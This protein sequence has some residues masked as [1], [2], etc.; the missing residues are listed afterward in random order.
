MSQQVVIDVLAVAWTIV[1]YFK[2]STLAYDL[3]DEICKHLS[4]DKHKLQQD[5][6]TR[7]NST[8]F[9]LESVHKQKMAL[10]AY[11]TEYGGITMLNSHQ[12]EIVRMVI[13]VLKPIEEVKWII[14]KNSACDTIGEDFGENAKETWWWW[15]WYKK[16]KIRND[17]IIGTEIWWNWRAVLLPCW[18]H[19]SKNNLFAGTETRL[20]A[21]Q[22]FI[23]N[24]GYTDDSNEPPNK[25]GHVMIPLKTVVIRFLLAKYGRS[26]LTC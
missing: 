21:R 3:L 24:C 11:S 18:I 4:I 16:N 7:W 9:M 20:P 25:K 2:H 5:E 13:L 22:Y 8:H 1:G 17:G 14:S 23:D 6:P 10:A 15:F 26:S 12:L 19:N